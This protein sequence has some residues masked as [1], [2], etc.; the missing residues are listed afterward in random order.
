[1][2]E[3]NFLTSPVKTSCLDAKD[4]NESLMKTCSTVRVAI[5]HHS[6]QNRHTLFFFS[7]FVFVDSSRDKCPVGSKWFLSKVSGV[8]SSAIICRFVFGLFF[9]DGRTALPLQ[10]GAQ[11]STSFILGWVFMSSLSDMFASCGMYYVHREHFSLTLYLEDF[12]VL[13]LGYCALFGLSTPI[14][15]SF[16]VGPAFFDSSLMDHLT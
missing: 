7:I 3:E 12:Y 4:E 5:L 15:L 14:P 1:M 11:C 8:I 9:H 13:E 10:P 2:G 6:A 16:S